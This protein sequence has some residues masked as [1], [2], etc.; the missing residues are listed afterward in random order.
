MAAIVVLAHLIQACIRKAVFNIDCSAI[1]QRIDTGSKGNCQAVFT[2][3]I[4]AVFHLMLATFFYE[5]HAGVAIAI[6]EIVPTALDLIPSVVAVRRTVVIAAAIGILHPYAFNNFTILI[7]LKGNAIYCITTADICHSFRGEIV[8]A[9]VNGLPTAGQ[10]A[11]IRIAIYFAI[12][13]DAGILGT[14]FADTVLTKVV[15]IGLAVTVCRGYQLNTG[16]HLTVGIVGIPYPA[17]T[18]NAIY[19]LDTFMDTGKQ[20]ATILALQQTADHL[21]VVTCNNGST[22]IH[23]RVTYL[24]ICSTG[25][26]IFCAGCFLIG[27]CNGIHM[28]GRIFTVVVLGFR[29]VVMTTVPAFIP[30]FIADVV[31]TG[32]T[33]VGIAVTA[34]LR[35]HQDLGTGEAIGGAILVYHIAGIDFHIQV[36]GQNASCC[37][38]V[39]VHPNFTVMT[40]N[41][42]YNRQLPGAD[43]DRNQDLIFAGQVGLTNC[44][45]HDRG[46]IL[47]LDQRVGCVKALRYF[48]MIQL[49][50]AD[51]IQVQSHRNRGNGFRVIC[52]YIN[53]V[54]RTGQNTFCIGIMCNHLHSCLFCR[55]NNNG[56]A[57]SRTIAHLIAHNILDGVHTIGKCYIFQG[58]NQICQARNCHGLGI[59]NTVNI[60]LGAG[61][62][63]TGIIVLGQVIRHR[64]AEGNDIGIHNI[65]VEGCSLVHAVHLVCQVLKH[66][67]FT[68]IHSLRI[69]YG[70]I[71]NIQNKLTVYIGLL[72]V[73]IAVDTVL[74][75]DIAL[76][77]GQTHILCTGYIDG[78]VMPA[79]L[80]ESIEEASAGNI[81]ANTIGKSNL[82]C[83][84]TGNRTTCV[85]I[86]RN[87]YINHHAVCF[88]GEVDPHADGQSIFQNNPLT[89]S[90]SSQQ[91]AGL[92]R[93]G[94][95]H[96]HSHSVITAVDMTA[97][98]ID[99]R[100]LTTYLNRVVIGSSGSI[101]AV[102]ILILEVIQNL[103]ALAYIDR[104]C[105]RQF[106]VVN[107]CGCQNRSI[108]FARIFFSRRSKAQSGCSTDVSRQIKLNV[109][110]GNRYL[111]CAIIGRQGNIYGLSIGNCH[112]YTVKGNAGGNNNIDFH[113]TNRFFL[114]VCS[115]RLLT[116]RA[117]GLK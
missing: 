9:A 38:I 20:V 80:I 106:S 97:G 81:V 117:I 116:Q 85:C 48:H 112:S 105:R 113:R 45:D 6:F 88:I 86:G 29:S 33:G 91:E 24:T 107:Q 72:T 73:N 25:V 30:G 64:S 12:T 62:I 42:L 63:Q 89:R 47:I 78:N 19:I 102:Q 13:E 108:V 69:V 96:L 74:H 75:A 56:T 110:T 60:D 53:V 35:H 50:D 34:Q 22:P 70:N 23:N 10:L 71:V 68:V 82:G 55:T 90:Q 15:V 67:S 103:G 87:L 18:H 57:D 101:P 84:I 100:S 61:S 52:H 46:N 14:V 40:V 2:E 7:K 3:V 66:R 41:R 16:N 4:P 114:I 79:G 59:V 92:Q 115:N 104:N 31:H 37:L 27:H 77:T 83:Q 32:R 36:H 109:C 39:I 8:P 94:V 5:V 98:C 11:Q 43:R 65:A 54:Q 21:I 93:I 95:I 76:Q 49:P 99:Q 51:V 111:E 58:Q 28:V 17:G 26:T 1:F 44:S